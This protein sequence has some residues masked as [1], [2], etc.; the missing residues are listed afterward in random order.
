[1]TQNVPNTEHNSAET[2]Y[3]WREKMNVDGETHYVIP[4]ADPYEYEHPFDGLYESPEA[5]VQA[6]EDLDIPSEESDRW[7]LMRIERTIVSRPDKS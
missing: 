5:A 2:F 1:M 3:G 6:L 7:V 4:R